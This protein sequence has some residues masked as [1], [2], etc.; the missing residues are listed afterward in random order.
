MPVID[1]QGVKQSITNPAF[2]DAQVDDFA[3]GKIGFHNTEVESGPFIE[4]IQALGNHVINTTGATES[5]DGTTYSSQKRI[6]NGQN[7]QVALGGID[8]AF[9]ETT[10]HTHDGTAGDGTQIPASNLDD[11]PLKGF[12]TQGIDITPITGLSTDVSLLLA[13]KTPSTSP[14]VP[15]VVV[16]APENKIVI[17]QGPPSLNTNDTYVDGGGNIVYGRLTELAGVWTLS[18]YVEIAAVETPYNFGVASGIRWYYQELFN[19]M[20]NPPVYSEFAS[21]P[22]DNTTASVVDATTAVKG[23]VLLPLATPSPVAATGAVGTPNATVANA[24][25][26][27]EGVHSVLKQGSTQR[28]GDITLQEGAGITI[29]EPAP[30]TFKINAIDIGRRVGTVSLGVG[31]KNF[32]IAF[33]SAMATT[34]YGVMAVLRNEVDSDPIFQPLMIKAK[35]VNGFDVLLQAETDSAFYFIDYIVY[36]YDTAASFIDPS[37][38]SDSDVVANGVQFHDVTFSA[39]LGTTNYGV[40]ANLVNLVDTDPQI[41]AVVI[42]VKTATGFRASWSAPTDSANYRLDY[43]ATPYV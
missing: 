31:L 25:H 36:T 37:R 24:D 17:R 12:V 27:H 28:L 32:T 43:I 26:V 22:S 6:T 3:E 5:A 18:Y 35:T 15:G 4:N 39:T 10:G 41:Q 23:K 20:V 9:H 29:D 40:V 8:S 34:A 1:G 21:I 14:L 2:V 42:T 30:G 7:H 13:G 16:N 19:P 33:S 38:R 11:V